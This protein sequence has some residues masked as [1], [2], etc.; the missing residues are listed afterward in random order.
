MLYRMDN[1]D[2]KIERPIKATGRMCVS[3]GPVWSPDGKTVYHVDSPNNIIME[4][5][6]STKDGEFQNGKWFLEMNEDIGGY[7]DGGTT[8]AE[9][10]VWWAIWDGSK[11]VKIN[12]N[13]RR[14]S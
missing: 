9:G 14:V 2:H 11:I 6:Y 1:Y 4:Y 3:N 10:N 13:T 7:F 12:P 5:N 8:D